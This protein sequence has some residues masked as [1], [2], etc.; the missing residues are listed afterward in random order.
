[1]QDDNWNLKTRNCPYVE[2]GQE[3]YDIKEV[4]KLYEK[5]IE[6][7]EQKREYIGFE[8][9][10]VTMDNIKEILDKRFGF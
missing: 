1:M 7:L 3:V 6:D 5:I 2:F 9:D 4:E 8:I 10:D